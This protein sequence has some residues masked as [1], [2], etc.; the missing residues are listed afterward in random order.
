MTTRTT[1]GATWLSAR[2]ALLPHSETPGLDAQLLLSEVTQRD[3]AWLLAHPEA[4]L[5][6][7]HFQSFSEALQ[8]CLAGEALPYVLGWWEFYGRRFKVDRSVLIPR[9]E[10]ELLVEHALAYL[11]EHA[12]CDVA[13]EVGTGSGCIAITLAAE[14]PHLQVVATD[15]DAAALRMAHVNA[16]RHSVEKRIRF[17]RTDLATTL[18]GPFDLICA[19]L[20][21]VPREDLDELTVAQREPRRALDG[22][23]QGLALIQALLADLPR[24]ISPGGRAL[25]EIDEGHG[26]RVLEMARKALPRGNAKVLPDLAGRDRL[27]VI[28]AEEL[29]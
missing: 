29:S 14:I 23:A 24:L 17:V 18:F 15:V 8:R 9:P 13:L 16:E 28:D 6:P 12:D 22:G 1:V 3:R 7:A 10:T 27:L 19:N 11:A 20:P 26:N 25:L 21:Y 4:T 5:D 2:R